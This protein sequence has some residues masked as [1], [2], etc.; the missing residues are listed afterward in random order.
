MRSFYLFPLLGLAAVL[1][2]NAFSRP[3]ATIKYGRNLSSVMDTSKGDIA[4]GLDELRAAEPGLGRSIPA[5]YEG[6]KNEVC[7]LVASALAEKN[8][9][10]KLDARMRYELTSCERNAEG[11]IVVDIM[12]HEGAAL[13]I[14]PIPRCG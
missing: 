1:S 10:D 3:P 4:R 13:V 9:R 12:G 5:C 2:S 6:K 8:A 11:A 7:G 14:P